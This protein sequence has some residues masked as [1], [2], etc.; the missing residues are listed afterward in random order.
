MHHEP[1]PEVKAEAGVIAEVM[2]GVAVRAILEVALRVYD[3]GPLVVPIQEEGDFLGVRGQA[4]PQRGGRGLPTGAFH[5]GHQNM[6]RLA[7]LPTKYPMLVVG[8]QSHSRCEG[9][10]KTH[11]QDSGLLLNS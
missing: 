11:L 1:A 10:A 5:F 8:T 6:V 7:S 2:A 9:P 3:Q 4:G